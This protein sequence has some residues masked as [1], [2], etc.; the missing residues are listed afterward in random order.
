MP[1]TCVSELGQH[2][3]RQW[4]VSCSAPSHYLKQCWLIVNWTNGNKLQWILQFCHFRSRK[5]FWNCHLSEWRP[6][7]S[8]R[9]WVKHSMHHMGMILYR[10]KPSAESF[11]SCLDMSFFISVY[12]RWLFLTLWLMAK[13]LSA[14]EHPR[15]YRIILWSYKAFLTRSGSRRACIQLVN[16]T[17][18]WYLVYVPGVLSV[19]CCW[20]S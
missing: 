16:T 10:G 2:K 17:V 13:M 15:W 8:R 11:R 20:M 4:L 12:W 1:H 19:V 7:L 9:K 14:S 5:Y 3:V 18:A 6:F